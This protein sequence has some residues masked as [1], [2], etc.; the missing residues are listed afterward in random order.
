MNDRI[1]WM[2][3]VKEESRLD[4]TLFEGIVV[5]FGF[6]GIFFFFSFLLGKFLVT[7]G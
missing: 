3:M 7:I 1:G 4:V 6:W 2:K 5:R